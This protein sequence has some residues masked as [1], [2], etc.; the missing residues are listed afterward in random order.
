MVMGQLP[1]AEGATIVDQGTY[2]ELV[3]RGRDFSNILAEQ[4]KKKEKVAEE[5]AQQVV[6]V[7]VSQQ[8][9]RLI[10]AF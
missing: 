6:S 7:P 2:E 5:E 8:R 9:N 4:K 10:R 1:G 3:G